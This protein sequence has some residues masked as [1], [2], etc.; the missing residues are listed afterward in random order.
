MG[1]CSCIS[2]AAVSI[3]HSDVGIYFIALSCMLLLSTA[4]LLYRLNRLYAASWQSSRLPYQRLLKRQ[5]HVPSVAVSPELDGADDVPLLA[6]RRSI[7]PAYYG[8]A[9]ADGDCVLAECD[10]AQPCSI[11]WTAALLFLLE[12]VLNLPS[13]SSAVHALRFCVR[14]R[15]RPASSRRPPSPPGLRHGQGP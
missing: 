10:R 9:A 1:V 11:A 12:A 5:L 2:T 6:R 15:A 13:A 4:I 3:G 14:V 7:L 8:C